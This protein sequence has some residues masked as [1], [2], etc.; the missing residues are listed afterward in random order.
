MHVEKDQ[1]AANVAGLF[2]DGWLVASEHVLVDIARE[3]P[4]GLPLS[5][6]R[7]PFAFA[8]DKEIEGLAERLQ[9][10]FDSQENL[11][12]RLV[13]EGVAALEILRPDHVRDVV[14]HQA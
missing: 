3:L 6:V 11:A 14:A 5:I 8:L 1:L 12:K 9:R 7:M 4:E 10:V 13:D 2:V